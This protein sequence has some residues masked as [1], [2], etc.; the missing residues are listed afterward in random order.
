MDNKASEHSISKEGILYIIFGI[1]TTVV[2]W[3]VYIF[4]ANICNVNYLTATTVSWVVAVLFA[5]ITNKIVVF[6]STDMSPGVVL[7]E[8]FVFTLA[9]ISTYVITMVGMWLGV[10]ILGF[11][12]LLVKAGVSV[13]VIVVNYIFSKFFIF[14]K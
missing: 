4:L 3:V 9:R 11:N 6:E 1:L 7:K 10:S 12:E 13:V 2:D 14:K 5:F 8:L